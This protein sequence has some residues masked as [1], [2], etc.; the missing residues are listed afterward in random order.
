MVERGNEWWF[1]CVEDQVVR[2]S[3]VLLLFDG[4]LSD[5]EG[6]VGC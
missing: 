5:Y 4:N 2:E 6:V 1:V 3:R